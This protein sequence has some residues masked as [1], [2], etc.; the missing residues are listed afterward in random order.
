MTPKE[1]EEHKFHLTLAIISS[2]GIGFVLGVA[3]GLIK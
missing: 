1:K 2:L 3:V